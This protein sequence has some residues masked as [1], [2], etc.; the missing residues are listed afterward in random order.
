MTSTVGAQLG[1]GASTNSGALLDQPH[2]PSG[3]QHNTWYKAAG[4]VL[5]LSSPRID[6]WISLIQAC[7]GV[8]AFDAVIC[9]H[10]RLEYYT[11]PMDCYPRIA[12]ISLSGCQQCGS[13][14]EG[15][16][17]PGES[18]E[19]LLP[20]VI[21]PPLHSSSIK[22]AQ[23]S[24]TNGRGQPS[25]IARCRH[26]LRD[27]WCERCNVWWCEDCYTPASAS[28]SR[29]THSFYTEPAIHELEVALDQGEITIEVFDEMTTRAAG[30][31][32]TANAQ[33]KEDQNPK[34]SSIKVHNH[35]CVSTCLME[36]ML[37]SVG[38]G[39]MWG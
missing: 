10:H 9:C 26:C 4:A 2:E 5:D 13:C 32:N 29:R 3:Q 23:R 7:A 30:R 14:P 19:N 36:E 35:L 20:L 11:A 15:P 1:A 31:Y 28:A 12:G 34:D 6:D 8:I 38:E 27:R 24:D 18:P 39:G 17:K 37:N 22:A 25:Y 33:A 21:P 16:A